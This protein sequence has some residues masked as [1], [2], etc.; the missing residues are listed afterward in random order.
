VRF[1]C[2]DLLTSDL[3]GVGVLVMTNQCWDAALGAAAAAKI[4]AELPGGAVVVEYRGRLGM[5]VARAQARSGPS[6]EPLG[7]PA[8]AAGATVSL[9]LLAATKGPVSWNEQ[10]ALYAWRVVRS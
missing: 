2:A 7:Q 9:E 10:Q 1:V 5:A 4:A 8:Q 6:C 3:R